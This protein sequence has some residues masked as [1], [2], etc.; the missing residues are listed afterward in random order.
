MTT[1]SADAASIAN[2][3]L[4]SFVEPQDRD[5]KPWLFAVLC[6]IIP[7]LPSYVVPFADRILSPALIIS[8]VLLGLVILRF[9]VDRRAAR[10][11]TVKPGVIIILLYFMLASVAYIGEASRTDY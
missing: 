6:L 10:I 3:G 7:L 9:V 1:P 4:N 11:T 2:A 8:G 5:E